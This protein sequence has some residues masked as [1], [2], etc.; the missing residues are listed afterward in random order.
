M[1]FECSD[2]IDTISL[3]EAVIKD[4]RIVDGSSKATAE[5]GEADVSNSSWLEI[6]A[7]AAIVK[8]GNSVNDYYADKYTDLM[9]IRFKNPVIEEILLEGHKYYDANDKLVETVPDKPVPPEDYEKTLE[10]FKDR[11]VFYGGRP[12]SKRNC[13]QMIID[14]ED[15]S[16]VIS[17]FYDKVTAGWNHFLNK[18]NV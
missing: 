11:E 2:E 13:Y 5:S 4:I 6:Q 17:F 8:N 14:V 12:D 9:E 1:I 18:A 15:D 7:D 10:L 16:Y 3:Q